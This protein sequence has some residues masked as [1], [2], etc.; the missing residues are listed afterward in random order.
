MPSK[1]TASAVRIARSLS[2]AEV[3]MNEATLR[4][5]ALGTEVLTAR[6]HGGFHPI[7]GQQAVDGIGRATAML[8]G[9]MR[10]MADAHGALRLTAEQHQVL[11]FGDVLDCP[12]HDQPKGIGDNVVPLSVAA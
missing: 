6:A 3:A 4:I 8:F 2:P 7:E 10:E 9:A 5:L 11:G 1:Q 12:P